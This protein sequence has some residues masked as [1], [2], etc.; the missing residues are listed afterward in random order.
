M[1]TLKPEFGKGSLAPAAATVFSAVIL[2]Y[3]IDQSAAVSKSYNFPNLFAAVML[4]FSLIWLIGEVLFRQ[5]PTLESISWRPVVAG[6]ALMILYLVSA[7]WLGFLI[8]SILMLFVTGIAFSPVRKS[9]RN[10]LISAA[11]AIIF[12]AVIYGL[13]NLMLKVQTPGGIFDLM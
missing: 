6:L 5:K 8:S 4:F 9:T 12:L 2:I 13:F 7:V 3:G 1:S 11:V 10:V